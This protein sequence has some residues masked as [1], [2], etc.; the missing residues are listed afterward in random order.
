MDTKYKIE[1]T[2]GCT[3]F[4]TSINDRNVLDIPQE[5]MDEI[6]DYLFVQIRESYNQSGILF[7][8]IVK[9]FQPDDRKHDPEPCGQCGDY[10]SSTTYNI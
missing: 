6:L 7:E 4:G 3:A 2:E 8:D 5:E 9:L 1:I 10:Y